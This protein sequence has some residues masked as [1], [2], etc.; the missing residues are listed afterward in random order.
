MTNGVNIRSAFPALGYLVASACL[1]LTGCGSTPDV[2]EGPLTPDEQVLAALEPYDPIYKLN[3]QG[4][5]VKIKLEG[6][7]IPAAVMD[8]VCQ[9]T[10][11]QHLS[12]Y[13]ASITDDSLVRLHSL[14]S[15]QSLGLGATP[16]S[17]VGI[18]HLEKLPSLR[19]VWLSKWLVVTQEV[20]QL[21]RALPDLTV[22]PQ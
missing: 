22:F 4:R 1:F 6:K 21:K 18:V 3:S 10:E 11:L 7:R 12:M 16:I 15:L 13:A 9:L 5:V 20:D 14:Q 8:Q 19:W 2:T 17:Q